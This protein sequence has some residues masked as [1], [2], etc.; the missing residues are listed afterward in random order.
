LLKGAK[1]SLLQKLYLA[2]VNDERLTFEDFVYL[3]EGCDNID[4]KKLDDVELY[5]ELDM[6]LS[7]VKR[8]IDNYFKKL[9]FSDDEKFIIWRI[10][11]SCLHIGN[12][13][14]DGKKYVE[15][16]KQT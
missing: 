2:N 3:K 14:L 7:K 16:G 5:N 11:A 6:Q 9:D 12:I 10:I 4:P 15:G 13:Q 1:I 8:S